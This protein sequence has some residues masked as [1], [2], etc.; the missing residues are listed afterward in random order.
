MLSYRLFHQISSP[1]ATR[2]TE[3]ILNF[4]SGEGATEID[5]EAE[6]YFVVKGIDKDIVFKETFL[7][8]PKI[9]FDIYLGQPFLTSHTFGAYCKNFIF[10]NFPKNYNQNYVES[11]MV[12]CQNSIK[13]K[14]LYMS[15]DLYL[16][17][18]RNQE[19]LQFNSLP[20]YPINS[21]MQ[22]LLNSS[23][24]IQPKKLYKDLGVADIVPQFQDSV[25]KNP[26]E[27]I[28]CVNASTNDE[29]SKMEFDNTMEKFDVDNNDRDD[30]WT[31]YQLHGK[32]GIPVSKFVEETGRVDTFEE[33]PKVYYE[34]VEELI[35][36]LDI[37]YVP[38]PQLD[39]FTAFLNN[40]CSVFSKHDLDI[41]CVKDYYAKVTMNQEVKDVSVKYI[42]VPKKL[43]KTSNGDG[44]SLQIKW[45]YGR[46]RGRCARPP[47]L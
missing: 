5:R 41:G 43:E 8:V 14:I 7:L 2:K 33:A 13:A 45:N 34:T 20:S 6:L 21:E 1:P 26:H 42:P 17:L 28:L 32:A 40:D 11:A 10:F 38:Q 25:I 9:R 16:R 44:R 19:S 39:E 29:R 46:M 35:D 24:G 30:L 12:N 3:V 31:S 4:A 23:H 36:L 47:N 37:F 18:T 27:E 22:Q 15:H